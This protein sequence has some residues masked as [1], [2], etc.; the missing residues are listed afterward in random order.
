MPLSIGPRSVISQQLHAV[1]YRQRSETFD[2][3]CVRYARTTA[4]DET[5]FRKLLYNLRTQ[6]TLPA[7]RQQRAVGWPHQTTAFN[8][9][10]GGTIPDDTRG[11]GDALTEAM[12]TLRSGG[13]C[14]WDFSSLRPNGEP[15][16]RLGD[17]A[18][19]SGPVSFMGIW[20]AMCSTIRS[21]GERRGAMMGVIDVRHPDILT[22]IRAKQDQKSLTNFNISVGITRD[23]MEAVKADSLYELRFPVDGPDS[24][25]FRS[26]RALDVWSIIMENNWDWAEPGVLFLD[27]INDMN[28]LRYCEYIRATNPCSEQ[29][30]PPNGACL[31]LSQNMVK[32]LVP[33][34][35]DKESK[36]PG[37]VLDLERFSHD[38]EV[39][40]R[41]CDNVFESTIFPLEA[42]RKE[43][44]A[45]RRMG[46]GVTGVANALEVCG[47]S[48]GSEGYITWQDRI[49]EI[50]R[51]TAYRTSIDMAKT[52]GSF[53]LFDADKWLAS[54]FARTL[55][56][57][58]RHDIRK[59]GLR[60][61][62]LLSIAP[63][64]TI[65][66]TA[67]NVSSGIEPPCSLESERI[68]QLADGARSI[69]LNDYALDEYGVRCKTA[70]DCT[71][72]QH[73]DVLCAAQ[74][75]VD[76]S[77]SK[78]TN[79]RGA[80]SSPPSPGEMGFTEFK[81]LYIMAYDG[82]AKGCATFNINGKRMGII[83]DRASTDGDSST[84]GASPSPSYK[85]VKHTDAPS[86][87]LTEGQSCYISSNGDKVCE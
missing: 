4:D 77:I 2:D 74:R 20:H 67:D 64:G 59:H 81:D 26:V 79:V 82:G 27:T 83:K 11:I 7:G 44:F 16:R 32:Y 37:Y 86:I 50:L 28:P 48:Y 6:A 42:Q 53:P 38:I 87:S 71:A 75:Y 80:K 24:R 21:A 22:F 35:K 23:F 29:P 30:L 52:K 60:N 46:I 31:L 34:Y 66:I 14:G 33:S 78:T 51:D 5:H 9:F 70:L 19:A 47:L 12:L 72:R 25:V 17:D 56:E 49:L 76:S 18:Y 40:V 1:K 39:A 55:P 57:D 43:A 63:T 84:N 41:A 58:I 65:S 54:G 13:G 36:G 68:I 15:I 69:P 8:C 45:K 85:D 62:L 73:I 10:V 3:Y 61:G